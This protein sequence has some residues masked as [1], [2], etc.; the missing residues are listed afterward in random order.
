MDIWCGV[1]A[2]GADGADD[3][4]GGA[5]VEDLWG[6]VGAGL[7]GVFGGA[8]SDRAADL[9]AEAVVKA[10]ARAGLEPVLAA[11]NAGAPTRHADAYRELALYVATAKRRH[12]ARGA[13]AARTKKKP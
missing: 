8:A 9:E 3:P 5:G 2:C 4:R 12:R 6:T 13:R 7:S 10:Y 1:H 11:V